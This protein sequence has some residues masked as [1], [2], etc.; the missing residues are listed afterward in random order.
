MPYVET[1][2]IRTFY[3]IFGSGEP[4]ALIGGSVFGRRNWAMA[5]DEFA[6]H[7][8][9]VS[10]DQRGYGRSDRPAERYTMDV[11]ID[12]LAGLLDALGID[13]AHIAGTS[14]GAMVALAFA[15]KYPDRC[16]GVVTDC[17]LVKPDRMRRMMFETWRRMAHAMGCGDAFADH[18]VTQAVG[19]DILDTDIADRLIAN[20]RDMVAQMPVETVIQACLIME[21]LDLTKA[22]KKIESPVLVIAS[23]LDYL[24][25]YKTAK[26]GAGIEY[27]LETLKNREAK[28]YDDIGHA[29]LLER[30]DVSI[31][32]IIDFLKRA[33]RPARAA[34]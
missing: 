30:K 16:L 11:W 28:I 25:P 7:F 1:N 22:V 14:M 5:W 24:C 32:L 13:R 10:Y 29:D 8:T 18:L 20:V 27:L 31:P 9:V 12:D 17:P 2:G 19:P 4:L 33:A 15:G 3:E 23:T 34:A 26:S 6:K 21:E